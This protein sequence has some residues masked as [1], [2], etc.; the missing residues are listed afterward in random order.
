MSSP[1]TGSPTPRRTLAA[2]L[3]GRLFLKYA[4]LFVG[5]VCA[6]LVANGLLDTWASFQEQ[7]ALL[8]R[9]QSEQARA[10][11]TRISLFIKDIERQL[12]WATQLPW[13]ADTL[14]QWRF[15][16]VRLLRQV[17][18]V[19][20]VAQLDGAGR[21]Q[22]RVSRFVKDALGR[23][24]DFSQDEFFIKALANKVYYGP[25]RFVGESEPY[26]TL[27]LAGVRRD[28]GVSVAEVNLKYIWDVVS[29]I[30]VG[31][32]GRAY[33]V[34]PEG[35][36]IAHPEISMVL[37]NTDASRLRQ[38]Q[39]ARAEDTSA[40][41]E[42]ALETNDIEG[43]RVLSVHAR[44]EPLGWLVFVELP[45]EEAYAPLYL[46]IQR[47]GVFII[48]ALVLATLAGLFL[49]RRMMIPIRALRDGAARIGSGD[50]GHRI[51]I[52]TGDELEALGGEF[53]SMAT[54]LQESH[55]TLESKIRD[56]TLAKSR[57][58]AAA[59][60]DLRQPLHALGLFVAQ[61]RTAST[62]AERSP[63][64]ERIDTAIATMNELFNSLLDISR[65]DAGALAPNMTEFPV[66]EVLKRVHTTFADSARAAGLRFRIVASSAWVRSDFVFLEQILLNLVS[67]A[68]RYT[69]HGGI[70]VG[71]RRR[72]GQLRIEVWDTGPG[73][74]ED[75]RKKIFGEFYRYGNPQGDQSVGLGLGLAIVDRLCSLLIHPVELT[76]TVGRG[77]RFA[78][79]APTAAPQR[80][81]VQAALAP[82]PLDVVAG[83]LIAVVDDDRLAL[84]GMGGLLKS[85]GC[86]IICG[87]SAAEVLANLTVLDPPPDLIIS[88]FHLSEGKTGLEAIEQLR[89]TIH[90]PV[91]AF[92]VSGDVSPALR[93][94]ARACGC[95]LLH[96]PVDPISLR[97]MLNRTLRKRSD[98]ALRAGS[99]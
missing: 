32:H 20:E 19:T 65:L 47:S 46:S 17:P 55:A 41:P 3:R 64:F 12:A 73:I 37:R 2:T 58:L 60:H 98:V 13:N 30:R 62:P 15:D 31:I 25:V 92:L 91:P 85:W 75:Q 38:V 29:Q 1:A 5:V 14:D 87:R 61:L 88:D 9:L 7:N 18:A 99:L 68:V 78:V 28:W 89:A 95:H 24:T 39:A 69:A 45:V 70:V 11:A 54:R 27:A 35:R 82:V 16:A 48:L 59:S 44:V 66:G 36:L 52:R 43:R 22:G 4:A 63:I 79:S 97:A 26:M 84:D 40:P 23:R 33:V 53:N 71:C 80:R 42:Q 86:R 83:K 74:P 8:I 93:D 21:E 50:L 57:L 77:S 10:A 6:A 81:A 51:V 76:S 96:K 94:Q 72:G 34:D 56:R 90:S 67:N 49:A